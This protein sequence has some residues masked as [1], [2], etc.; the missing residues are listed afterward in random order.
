MSEQEIKSLKLKRSHCK[1][2]LTNFEKFLDNFERERD[3]SI[4]TKR[5]DLADTCFQDFDKCQSEIKKI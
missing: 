4:L 2:T 5:S 3:L 1:R